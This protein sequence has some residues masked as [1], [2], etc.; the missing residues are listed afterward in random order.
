MEAMIY[1]LLILIKN[2]FVHFCHSKQQFELDHLSFIKIK[3]SVIMTFQ[4][5][6]CF[7]LTECFR[8]SWS[9]LKLNK[10]F[11]YDFSK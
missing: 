4:H 1:N 6:L 2:L 7:H 9:Y 11:M 3:F 8:I 10:N 5:Y